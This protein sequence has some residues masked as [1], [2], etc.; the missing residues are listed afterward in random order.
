MQGE[1]TPATH[2]DSLVNV[3]ALRHVQIVVTDAGVQGLKQV[4]ET[5]AG[6]EESC[7]MLIFH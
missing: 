1:I 6:I 5:S 3:A 7:W 2:H 4:V